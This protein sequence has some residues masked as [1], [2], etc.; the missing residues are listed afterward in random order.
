VRVGHAD[1]IDVRWL[2]VIVADIVRKAE[3]A[4]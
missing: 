1:Q 3:A 4:L 2:A